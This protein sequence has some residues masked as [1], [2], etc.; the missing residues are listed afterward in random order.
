EP[1]KQETIQR[2]RAWCKENGLTN[3]NDEELN[4]LTNLTSLSLHECYSLQNVDGL[5]NLT[6]LTSL[7]LAGCHS[8]QNV[9]GLQNLTNLTSLNLRGC[10][11]LPNVD[12]LHYLPKLTSLDLSVCHLLQNVDVLQYLP[13]LTSLDLSYCFGLQNVD[14]LQNLTN[15]TSLDLSRCPR[16]L[17]YDL[18]KNLANLTSL[19]LSDCHSLQNV[20]VL[21]NLSNL[22]C[23]DLSDCNRLLNVDGLQN[24]TNLTSLFLDGCS[25]LQNVDGLQYLTNLTRLDLSRCHRLQNVDVMQN[26]T[27]LTSLDLR[28]CESL[29]NVDGLQ[30]LTN[31][32]SLDL[33]YC[34]SLQNVEGLRSLLNLTELSMKGNKQIKEVSFITSLKGL[35]KLN[36]DG[37]P[38]IRDIEPLTQISSL[39]ELK[40]DS[41]PSM[42]IYVLIT[43]SLNRNDPDWFFEKHKEIV[44]T[45]ETMPFLEP[46][47][48]TYLDALNLFCFTNGNPLS[49]TEKL[50]SITDKLFSRDDLREDTLQKYFTVFRRIM[51]FEGFRSML[52]HLSER[53]PGKEEIIIRP[54]LVVLSDAKEEPERAWAREYVTEKLKPFFNDREKVEPLAPTVCLF[55]AKMNTPEL[56]KQWMTK[57]N[58][59][60]SPFWRNNALTALIGWKASEGDIQGAQKILNEVTLSE[61]DNAI[62]SY[63]LHLIKYKKVNH[64]NP[65]S[66]HI[67]LDHI[68]IITELLDEVQDERIKMKVAGE[69]LSSIDI[70]SNEGI[71]YSIVQTL[72]T[73]P[74]KLFSLFSD[75]IEK[76]TNSEIIPLIEGVIKGKDKQRVV[77]EYITNHLADTTVK[78]VTKAEG[79]KRSLKGI[80]DNTINVD[81]II[82]NTVITLLIEEGMIDIKDLLKSEWI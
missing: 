10:D 72:E 52:G 49:S 82:F 41:N 12:V 67:G 13:N 3:L 66:E 31:L 61:K 75:I 35:T 29:Q 80:S 15:L 16:L 65:S 63:I 20:D 6:N 78:S 44:E 57:L 17:N 79:R 53:F 43:A 8:L 60:E 40:F 68:R 24:L 37:C 39:K 50:T 51:G 76:Y 42:A 46:L 47:T 5:Q 21:Q 23:L 69:I 1:K 4:D 19:K 36:L 59:S 22:T 54:L 33:S 56:V 62:E 14:V 45:L 73:S 48:S 28:K 81:Q 18:L 26:L 11:R 7:V 64:L 9:D 70:L 25:Y 32:T 38:N 34:H 55:Y 27:N 71:F 2:F 74:E 58:D 30:N 77:M